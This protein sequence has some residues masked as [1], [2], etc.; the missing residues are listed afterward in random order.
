MRLYLDRSSVRLTRCMTS[1][2]Y[3]AT[4]FA[5]LIRTSVVLDEL[6]AILPLSG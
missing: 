5:S 4:N 2:V 3:I 6:S 1:S